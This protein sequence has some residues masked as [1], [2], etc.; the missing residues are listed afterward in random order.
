[1]MK[2]EHFEHLAKQAATRGEWVTISRF[3][4]VG[5][6]PQMTIRFFDIS[7]IDKEIETH[8][9]IPFDPNCHCRCR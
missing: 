5:K 3:A 8:D 7:R 4:K 9:C 6:V 1:M 2:A